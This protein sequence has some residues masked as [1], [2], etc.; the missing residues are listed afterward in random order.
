MRPG[1]G[2]AT[3]EIAVE[4]PLELLDA[5]RLALVAQLGRGQSQL[6]GPLGEAGL[7][8]GHGLVPAGHELGGERAH[9][10]VPGHER[11]P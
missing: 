10:L 7:Q 2:R 9:L 8:R 3:L 6:A 4:A 1:A 5:R 11:L